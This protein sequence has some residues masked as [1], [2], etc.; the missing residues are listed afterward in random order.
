VVADPATLDRIGGPKIG[1][2]ELDGFLGRVVPVALDHSEK[3]RIYFVEDAQ[4]T[5]DGCLDGGG[6]TGGNQAGVHLDQYS[7]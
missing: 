3:V 5:A 4:G 7:D 1:M 2:M 6:V